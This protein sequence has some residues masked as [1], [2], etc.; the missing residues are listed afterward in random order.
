MVVDP[1]CIG[2]GGLEERGRWSILDGS[3]A[4]KTGSG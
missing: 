1:R 2:D 4:V 3:R